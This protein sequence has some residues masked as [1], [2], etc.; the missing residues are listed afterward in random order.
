M[1][2]ER[3]IVSLTTWTPRLKNIP[4]VLDSIFAQTVQPDLV[5]INFSEGEIIPQEL[6]Q[7]L[8]DHH[9]ECNFVPDTKVYKKLIPTLKKYPN[10]CVIS[11]D[12]DWIYPAGMIEDFMEI[13]KRYP[14]NPI[15]GNKIIFNGL[16]CHCGCASLTQASFLGDYLYEINSNIIDN[17]P[18]DDI[19]YTFLCYKNGHPYIRTTNEYFVNLPPINPTQS[20][21]D[22]N[23]QCAEKTI[24]YLENNYG[25][26]DNPFKHYIQDQ[27]L[28]NLINELHNENIIQ[29]TNKTLIN[30]ENKMR[31]STAYRIGTFIL[32]PYR[33]IK[34]LFNQK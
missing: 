3:I 17:C 22:Q 30:T 28:A 31:N 2:S 12:D 4:I 21:S 18:S 7:Y 1:I 27:Y 5:V 13:H 16:T 6:Q 23:P 29:H 25:I 10:D 26:I 20:Y 33:W 24:T 11:I 15:S 19:L 32:K 9:V 14:D 8:D 34:K